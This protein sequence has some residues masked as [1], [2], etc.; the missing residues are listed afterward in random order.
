[1]KKGVRRKDEFACGLAFAAGH[2]WREFHNADDVHTIALV[3]FAT[4]HRSAREQFEEAGAAEYDL[5]SIDQ[6]FEQRG[7]DA[8]YRAW[9]GRDRVSDA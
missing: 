4:D 9:F 8:K 1:M 5:R 7:S 3:H 6:A 2:V